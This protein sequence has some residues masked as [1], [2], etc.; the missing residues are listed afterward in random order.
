MEVKIEKG[1]IKNIQKDKKVKKIM[2]SV[3]E[4]SKNEFFVKSQTDSKKM[5]SVIFS[6]KKNSYY[7]LCRGF[8]FK[9][10]CSHCEAVNIYRRY[11]EYFAF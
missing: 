1:F 11:K 6:E 5:Y 4:G 10:N 9:Q 7:C 2:Q 8:T 3:I